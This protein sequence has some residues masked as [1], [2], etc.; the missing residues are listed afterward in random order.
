MFKKDNK[1]VVGLSSQNFKDRRLRIIKQ[2]S[3]GENE[4]LV[5]SDSTGRGI[6]VPDVSC[7]INYD[8]PKTDRIFVHRVGRTA[9]AGKAGTVL[10]F[11][12]KAEVIIL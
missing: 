4:I 9:R 3:S 2:F 11:A 1:N 10:S 7:V 6:D 12:T 5:T 8:L